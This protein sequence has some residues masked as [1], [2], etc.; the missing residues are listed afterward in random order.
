M[1]NI[2]AANKAGSKIMGAFVVYDLPDRDCAALA[3]NGEFSLANGGAAKY[4]AYIDSI[5]AQ[6]KKYP[7][8]R[9]ALVI[10]MSGSLLDKGLASNGPTEPDSLGNLVTNLNV[11]KCQNAASAYRD[12]IAYAIK[13][14]NLPNVAMYIDAGHAGWLGWQANLQPA[15]DLFAQVYKAAGSPKA[16]KGLVTK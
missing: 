10:G 16:V 8:V 11:P 6:L 3:S 13:T 9:T 1:A 5:A 15:A 7:D 4:R 12:G 14:L 2:R